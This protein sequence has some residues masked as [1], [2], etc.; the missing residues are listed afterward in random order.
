MQSSE[1]VLQTSQE[2]TPYDRNDEGGRSRRPRK[3]RNQTRA[4]PRNEGVRHPHPRLRHGRV[5]IRHPHVEDRER[6][7]PEPPGRLLDGARILDPGTS[8]FQVGDRVVFW[9]NL[10]C[11]EC[12]MCRAGQEHLCREV[13]GTNYIGFVCNGA[14]A[15]KFVEPAR[16]AYRLPDTVSDVDAALIDPLMVAYHAVHLSNMKL[17]DKV[18]VVAQLMG[19]L[20]K[21]AGASLV[22]MSK[23]N[24]RK[25]AK[26]REM[27]KFD[28]YIDGKDPNRRAV[29]EEVSQGGFDVVFEAVGSASALA[30]AM[31]AV[32]AGG[33]IV[34]V[35]NTIDPTIPF[36][37]N[38]LVLHEIRLVG[39]VSC[40]RKKFE[41]TIDLIASGMIKPERYV[42]DIVPVEGMQHA[43]ERLTS[44]TDPVLKIVMKPD[45]KAE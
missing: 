4:R 30:A 14:Y 45:A 43:F 35:G 19:D 42:T 18:L 41:E 24:D 12:D 9:A 39:S 34:T 11:G 28:C 33:T 17:H 15:E 38:R 25:L 5:R 22:A 31:D 27:G 7:E 37:I 23:T 21:S 6:L 8:D 3:D 36:D 29:Y 16:L 20:A 1:E 44:R 40:T 26:A 32:K 2:N 13:N 10:Y